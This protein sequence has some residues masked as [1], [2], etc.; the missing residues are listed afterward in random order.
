M[1]PVGAGEAKMYTDVRGVRVCAECGPVGARRR[2]NHTDVRA[3]VR[4]LGAHSKN[5]MK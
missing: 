5:R 1:V 2:G 3:D 4:L